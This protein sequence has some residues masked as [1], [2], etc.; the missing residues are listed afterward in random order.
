MSN[1]VYCA[2]DTV[3]VDEA[4]SVAQQILPYVGGLKIGMEYF[5]ANG[6]AGYQAIADLGAPIFLDL[7]FHDIPNTVAGAIRATL[8]LKP[9]IVNVH[10]AG[11]RAMMAAA[12]EEAAK[13]GQDRPKVI[14]VTILTSLL[15]DDLTEVGYAHRATDQ[16]RRMAELAQSSGLDGVVCS[17]HEIEVLRADRG[18]DFLLVTPGIRPAGSDVGDQKRVMTPAEA[19][20][21]GTDI[22]V[23]GRPIFR[24]DNPAAAAQAIA[25]SIQ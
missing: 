3:Q 11:G 10:A 4:V 7:K 17:T 13:A 6:L 12:A 2:L 20:N 1:P 15:D 18:S 19:K 21:K 9:A 14:A 16:V 22:M 25:D 8:P 24:A 23:I 5:Y